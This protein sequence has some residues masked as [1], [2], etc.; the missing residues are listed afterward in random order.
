MLLEEMFKEFISRNINEKN[1]N[2]IFTGFDDFQQLAKLPQKCHVS[3]P[4]DLKDIKYAENVTIDLS[5]IDVQ[6]ILW[7]TITKLRLRGINLDV[8]ENLY[9]CDKFNI[10]EFQK[11]LRNKG[12]V[13]QMIFYNTEHL[14]K[15]AQ[16]LFNELYYFNSMYFNVTTFTKNDNFITYFLSSERV[17]DNREN[18]TKI[19]LLKVDKPKKMSVMLDL[20]GTSSKINNDTAMLFVN[21]L[22]RIRKNLEADFCT[23]SMSTHYGDPFV[24]EETLD[25]LYRYLTPEIKFGKH[26]YLYGEYDYETKECTTEDYMCNSNKITTFNNNIVEDDKTETIWVGIFDDRLSEDVYKHYYKDKGVLICRPSQD[27]YNLKYNSFVNRATMTKD[28]DGV[29]EVL[30]EYTRDIEGLSLEELLNNQQNMLMHLSSCD[31]NDKVKNKEF[32][33]LKRYLKE[34]YADDDDFKDI[35]VKISIYLKNTNFTKEELEML[36]EILKIINEKF[37]LDQNKQGLQIV[38][39]FKRTFK[40]Y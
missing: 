7:F 8:P 29:V 39:E 28:F 37:E 40:L 17:L 26:F 18:Y 2:Y 19:K 36:Y 25:I 27:E 11:M 15:E 1:N 14:T 5:K 9:F 24:A 4:E 31:I 33:F 6:D 22:E 35:L 34:G 16:M 30:G 12:I 32:I 10:L 21:Y 13:V 38:D 20:G 23:I 3:M